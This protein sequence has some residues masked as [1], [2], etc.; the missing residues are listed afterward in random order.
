MSLKTLSVSGLIL[1]ALIAVSMTSGMAVAQQPPEDE[2]RLKPGN[3]WVYRGVV[4][5]AYPSTPEEQARQAPARLGKKQIVWKLQILEEVTRDDLKAYLVKGSLDQLSW[6]APGKKEEQSLWIVCKDRFYMLVM[7]PDLLRRFRDPTDSL[8]SAV[9][10]EE[11]VLQFPSRLSQCTTPIA[12]DQPR[13]R[14]DLFYCWYLEDKKLLE[15]AHISGV[16]GPLTVWKAWYRSL[17]DHQIYGFAPGWGFV[18]Y[19]FSHHGTPSEAH[20]KLVEAHL[21]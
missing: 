8:V 11:P 14:D 18:S 21:H 7:D 19:D 13:Q 17:P 16:T 3:Y 10:K 1:I 6:Y 20:V 15:V 4:K 2:L 5:W 12:P 9:L